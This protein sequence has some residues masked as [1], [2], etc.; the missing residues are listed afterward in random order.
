MSL[1]KKLVSMLDTNTVN[2]YS[3][4]EGNTKNRQKGVFV[5]VFIGCN[6]SSQVFGSV[7]RKSYR[8]ICPHNKALF[9]FIHITKL[10]SCDLTSGTK[11]FSDFV[12]RD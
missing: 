5:D 7:F 6:L 12:V 3:P 4:V 2:P 10:Y 1:Q 9:T 11:E 8:S